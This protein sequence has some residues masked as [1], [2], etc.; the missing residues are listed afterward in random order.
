MRTAAIS[1]VA[2]TMLLASQANAIAEEHKCPVPGTEVMW[3]ESR[4]PVRYEGQEGLWCYRFSGG[5]Q[6]P[7][8][9]GHIRYFPR[10]QHNEAYE[11]ALK[12]ATELSPIEPGKKLLF[13]FQNASGQT[14]SGQI[15]RDDVYDKFLKGASELWPIE[16]AKKVTFNFKGQSDRAFS[17]TISVEQRETITVLAGTF[18]VLP[19]IVEIRNIGG[20]EYHVRRSFYYS[21]DLG[22]N[23][24]NDF[25]YFAGNARPDESPSEL[26][27]V[28]PPQ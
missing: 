7:S 26:I 28:K 2:T 12:A 19:L 20:R 23:V 10:Y 24:K 1:G 18:T 3:T 27:S 22:M 17:T 9:L 15:L 4:E 21:P 6:I 5:R 25:Q 13:N 16:P 8:E 14:Y 11:K